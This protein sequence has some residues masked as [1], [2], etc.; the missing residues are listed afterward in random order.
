MNGYK[1][2]TDMAKIL[3][4]LF[5]YYVTLDIIFFLNLI[6]ISL[7]AHMAEILYTLATMVG[8]NLDSFVVR[9]TLHLKLKS[10]F[11]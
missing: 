1:Y 3:R 10:I 4:K 9:S 8:N 11:F 6:S 7:L 5:I 2:V